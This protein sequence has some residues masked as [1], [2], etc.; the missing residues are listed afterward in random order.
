M[1]PMIEAEEDRASVSGELE[2]PMLSSFELF[3]ITDLLMEITLRPCSFVSRPVMASIKKFLVAGLS[4]VPQPQQSSSH[5]K[6]YST[7]HTL[8]NCL[9]L[10]DETYS[11][12]KA[13]ESPFPKNS[14]S[15]GHPRQRRESAD[16]AVETGENTGERFKKSPKDNHLAKH[17]EFLE[18]LSIIDPS[19]SFE[20]FFTLLLSITDQT[21][22]NEMGEGNNLPIEFMVPL[23]SEVSYWAKAQ[24]SSV[25]KTAQFKYF[26]NSHIIDELKKCERTFTPGSTDLPDIS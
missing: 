14:H 22:S 8:V 9:S 18:E 10:V 24:G 23:L 15:R 21:C 6:F 11:K 3:S 16:K 7:Y 25:Y 2:Y 4:R 5:A 19:L 17:H 26:H 13:L 20:E 1:S 12:V